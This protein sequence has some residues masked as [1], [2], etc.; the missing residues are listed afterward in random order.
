[1]H[2]QS[3]P[4]TEPIVESSSCVQVQRSIDQYN[5]SKSSLCRW[6]WLR[7]WEANAFTVFS[8]AF[9]LPSDSARSAFIDYYF[10]S[11][12]SE[13]ARISWGIL[14]AGESKRQRD[15][16]VPDGQQFEFLSSVS[17]A[18]KWRVTPRWLATCNWYCTIRAQPGA[19]SRESSHWSCASQRKTPG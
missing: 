4:I 6:S 12:G 16:F 5:I 18:E 2:L 17:L 10:S 13:Q 19:Q 7:Y 15:R 1:M 14:H 11:Y 3:L 9:Q 8:Q